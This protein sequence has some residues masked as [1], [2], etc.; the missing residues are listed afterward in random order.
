VTA[1]CL[2]DG[3]EERDHGGRVGVHVVIR[4][5]FECVAARGEQVRRGGEQAGVGFRLL[6][7]HPVAERDHGDITIV[8]VHDSDRVASVRVE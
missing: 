1:G 4:E 3:S 6:P 2:C 8:R 7:G 5:R